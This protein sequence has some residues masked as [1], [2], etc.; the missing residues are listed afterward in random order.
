MDERTLTK[1][2]ILFRTVQFPKAYHIRGDKHI[3]EFGTNKI[4]VQTCDPVD[5]AAICW[6][7]NN[8]AALIEEVEN[9]NA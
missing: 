5:A 7:I 2:K 4:L 3:T 6:A 9:A 8:C 1:G